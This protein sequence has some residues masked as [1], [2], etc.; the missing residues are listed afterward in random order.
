MGRFP[1]FVSVESSLTHVKS[2]RGGGMVRFVGIVSAVPAVRIVHG[3]EGRGAVHVVAIV[4]Q[5][6]VGLLDHGPQVDE[7]ES[8]EN[9]DPGADGAHDDA[10]KPMRHH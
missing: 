4:P 9:G 3:L 5:L 7:E 1:L 6:D 10:G 2:L 8:R